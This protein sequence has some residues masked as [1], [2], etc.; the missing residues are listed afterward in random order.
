M[1]ITTESG[2]VYNIENGIATIEGNNYFAVKILDNFCFDL[3]SIGGMS[4]EDLLGNSQ[5]HLPLQVGKH[6]V[7]N[8]LHEWRVS[9]PIVSIEKDITDVSAEGD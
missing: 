9:T 4:L 7:V 1:K 2:T 8:G 6:M 3:E 5:L